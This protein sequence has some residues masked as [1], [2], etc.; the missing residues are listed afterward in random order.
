MTDYTDEFRERIWTIVQ[1]YHRQWELDNECRDVRIANANKMYEA[2]RE[3][4]WQKYIDTLEAQ[5]ITY[6]MADLIAA[7]WSE[8]LVRD[9]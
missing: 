5:G 3:S 9:D 8:R 6:G 7:D 4:Q 1:D 2:N